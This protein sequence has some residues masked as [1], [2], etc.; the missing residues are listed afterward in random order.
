MKKLL[1]TLCAILF[2]MS[3]YAQEH[4]TFKGVSMGCNI[5][6]FVSQ[7]ESKG[8]TKK[9]LQDNG[10]VLSGSFAGKDD[11][12]I[13]VLCTESTK[14]VWKVA[15]KFPEQ[16]SWYSL[17]SEYNTLK[18]SYT[19]KYGTPKSYEF[20]SSPYYE[21]DGY[22]LQALR[23]D[24]CT[25]ASYFST[26]VGDIGLEMTDDKCIRVSYEDAANVKIRRVEKERAV[27]SD[28]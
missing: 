16:T 11:C 3:A 19:E 15:V 28:I 14:T 27:S 6:T 10:A 26:P 18:A 22:E 7:L 12:I 24:K 8:Y 13:F 17:K 20:F 25:Y 4:M 9:L 21:G 5:T 2:A 1:L 23:M